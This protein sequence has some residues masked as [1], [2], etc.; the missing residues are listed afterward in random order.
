MR[1]YD[2]TTHSGIPKS[3]RELATSEDAID[4]RR[5][6]GGNA[7]RLLHSYSTLGEHVDNHLP[8]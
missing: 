7:T 2:V 3:L 6:R 8:L 1:Q 4:S 5:D